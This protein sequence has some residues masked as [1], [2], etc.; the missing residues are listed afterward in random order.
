MGL[1]LSS[2]NS[3]LMGSTPP[4]S[5]KRTPPTVGRRP[6]RPDPPTRRLR[7]RFCSLSLST[8]RRSSANSS[9]NRRPSP[10]PPRSRLSAPHASSTY[11]FIVLCG[12]LRHGAWHGCRGVQSSE[13][14]ISR[15][16][17]PAT[18]SYTLRSC[19]VNWARQSPPSPLR[20]NDALSSEPLGRPAACSKLFFCTLWLI[21]SSSARAPRSS[22]TGCMV[23]SGLFRR[24]SY[25]TSRKF[26][27]KRSA[28]S[29]EDLL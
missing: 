19:G 25:F 2:P 21:T 5:P 6:P 18:C 11:R 15:S 1:P 4:K 8:F 16:V 10:T 24:S 7:R 9:C 26:L 17:W 28:P 22:K 13:Y 29:R 20:K 23:S 12:Y 27:P 14:P 3:R